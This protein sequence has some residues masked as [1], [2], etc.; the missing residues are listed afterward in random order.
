MS[1][2]ALAA[3]LLCALGLGC[4]RG[5]VRLTAVR[6]SPGGHER[7]LREAGLDRDALRTAAL[8]ALREAGFRP[9][10][11]GPGY[12]AR[13]EIQSAAEVSLEGPE[14]AVTITV[15]LQLS[16]ED[17][18]GLATVSAGGTGTHRLAGERGEAWRKALAEAVRQASGDVRV[19]LSA[20]G[21]PVAQLVADLAS[22]D[23]RLREQAIRVLGDRRSRPAV[24]ALIARLDDP[25]PVLA[26]RAAGALARI[27]DPRAVTPIIDFSLRFEEGRHVARYA[28][29]VGDIGGSEVRGY[30]MTLES[31]HLDPDVRQSAREALADLDAREAEQARVAAKAGTQ[32]SRPGSGSMA[33]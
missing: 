30:L 1:R 12:R 15:E 20:E 8:E 28:R 26:E 32:S 14:R 10:D 19:A 21:K 25:D 22:D 7:A 18:H 11:G 23:P 3:T 6:A 2:R 4:D 16:P 24:P 5:T 9:V 31:G 29:I 13:V 27:G 17:G 33:R